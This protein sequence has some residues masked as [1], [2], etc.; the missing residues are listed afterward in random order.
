M[1]SDGS[2]SGPGSTFETEDRIFKTKTVAL[3]PETDRKP[4]D[5]KKLK[6]ETGRR[7]YFNRPIH[8]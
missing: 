3:K 2:V 6:T 8:H 7:P 4:T 1:I 5:K